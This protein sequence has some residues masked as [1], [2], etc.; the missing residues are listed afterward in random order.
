MNFNLNIE[1]KDFEIQTNH[2]NLDQKSKIDEMIH[3]N[4]SIFAKD[5]YDVGSV[6]DFEAH[7]DLMT[8][9]PARYHIAV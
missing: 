8:N 7:I 5:E 2:S 4:K 3:E 6:S 9:N 1:R